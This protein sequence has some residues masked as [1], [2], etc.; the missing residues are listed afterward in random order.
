MKL[1]HEIEPMTHISCNQYGILLATNMAYYLQLR[2]MEVLI[3][4]QLAIA[5]GII[6]I[7]G[8]IGIRGIIL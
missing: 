5:I 7:K 4:R 2:K 6:G 3:I 1:E 8:I